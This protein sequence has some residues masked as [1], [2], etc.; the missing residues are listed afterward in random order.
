[1]FFNN[2]GVSMNKD[3]T[4]RSQTE[5]LHSYVSNTIRNDGIMLVF[6]KI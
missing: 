5:I 6:D 1:M 3:T 4:L 2:N